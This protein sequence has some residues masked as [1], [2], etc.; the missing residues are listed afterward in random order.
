M[1]KKKA[2]LEQIKIVINKL[3]IEYKDEISSGIM[4]L[5]YKRYENALD[6]LENNKD[7]KQINIIGGVRAYMDSYSDYNNP[8]LGQLHKAEKL[9]KEIK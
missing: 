8:I 9:N 2:L 6:I 3:E 5:I 4:Q 7:I 1:D